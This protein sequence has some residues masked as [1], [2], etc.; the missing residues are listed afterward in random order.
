MHFPCVQ[1][2]DRAE[3]AKVYDFRTMAVTRGT[4]VGIVNAGST[5][6]SPALSIYILIFEGQTLPRLCD[7]ARYSRSHLVLSGRCEGRG[8]RNAC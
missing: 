3:K 1:A 6:M 5:R 7:A 2:M 8:L 4:P